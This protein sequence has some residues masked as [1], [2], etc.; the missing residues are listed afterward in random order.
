MS[1]SDQEYLPPPC[2]AR[3][4]PSSAMSSTLVVSS[5]LLPCRFDARSCAR[6]LVIVRLRVANFRFVFLLASPRPPFSFLCSHHFLVVV[7]LL[8]R[9]PLRLQTYTKVD[10][11]IVTIILVVGR[12]NNMYFH[13]TAWCI[14]GCNFF[15]CL[16]PCG[17][18]GRHEKK[19]L[20]A[21]NA[22]FYF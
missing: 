9:L 8:Y 4:H 18:L 16:G 7:V 19:S 11:Y 3:H 22:L 10:N 5:F 12:E 1:R 17:E 21:R 2:C 15:S 13:D 20:E 14:V 6:R